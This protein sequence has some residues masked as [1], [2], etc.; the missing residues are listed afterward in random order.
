MKQAD[1]K[2]LQRLADMGCIVC[3]TYYHV[4]SPAEIHHIRHGMGMGQRA[5]HSQ[6]IPLCPAHHRTGGHGVALHAGQ[7]AFEEKYATE[8]ELLELTRRELGEA[9]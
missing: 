3:R 9:Y 5:P 7:K 1:R 2:H 4:H 8:Q 6:A